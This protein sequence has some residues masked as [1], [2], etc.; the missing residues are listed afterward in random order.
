M[1]ELEIRVR[2]DRQDDIFD[3]EVDACNV[4]GDD[5]QSDLAFDKEFQALLQALSSR[6]VELAESP[7]EDEL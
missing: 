3:I 7:N 5:M 1:A 6:F 4:D 2:F